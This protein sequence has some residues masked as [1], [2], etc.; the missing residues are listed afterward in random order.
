MFPTL[1]LSTVV[2]P[3]YAIVKDLDINIEQNAVLKRLCTQHRAARRKKR[4]DVVLA[5]REENNARLTKWKDDVR[6]IA[7]RTV[8]CV[9]FSR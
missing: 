2:V 6:L 5:V 4:G 7:A 3:S 9:N 8:K 1:F